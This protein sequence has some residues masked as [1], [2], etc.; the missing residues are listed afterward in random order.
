VVTRRHFVSATAAAAG[1][2][3]AGGCTGRPMPAADPT[4]PA[5]SGPFRHGVASGDPLTDRVIL[6]TRVSGAGTSPLA[7]RWEIASDPAFRRIV[8]QGVV[9]ALPMRDHTVKVDALGLEPARTY[10][11]RFAAAGAE[12]RVGRTRTLPELAVSRLR[13]AVASCSN[14]PFGYTFADD[15][16]FTITVAPTGPYRFGSL[17]I[18]NQAPLAAD[19]RDRVKTPASVGCT[20]S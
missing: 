9:T 6:W 1:A 8:N 16:V 10:Y 2:A 11:Y 15:T 5:G 13:I 19:R 20:S 17:V 12:S 7:V 4:L 14:L 18:E 3:A